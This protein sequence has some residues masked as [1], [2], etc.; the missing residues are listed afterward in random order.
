[1]GGPPACGT[2]RR[3]GRARGRARF[4]AGSADNR[5]SSLRGS[6][7]Q[8]H[9]R[10]GRAAVGTGRACGATTRRAH[11]R[12]QGCA[13]RDRL[14]DRDRGAN[15]A[16]RHAAGAGRD[17]G[18]SGRDRRARLCERRDA[19][20][21]ARGQARLRGRRAT[22]PTHDRARRIRAGCARRPPDCRCG[23][24][25]FRRRRALPQRPFRSVPPASSGRCHGA[26]RR[27][28]GGRRQHRAAAR[29]RR[30]C[31][32][33]AFR[34]AARAAG[35]GARGERRCASV[36]PESACHGSQDRS[37]RAPSGGRTRCR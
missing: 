30:G 28:A 24:A 7:S 16:P 18:R 13:R 29:G 10:G 11:H 22:A 35:D 36:R 1:M 21:S 14:P 3:H 5:Q 4:A 12:S 9:R 27:A 37:A 15:A 19:H 25:L 20:R 33:H 32:A 2:D 6:R 23:R 34:S 31:R 26:A 8:D 17:H